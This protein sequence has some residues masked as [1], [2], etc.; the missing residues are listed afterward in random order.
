MN[1]KVYPTD[2]SDEEWAFVAPDLTLT[3]YSPLPLEP[4]EMF[5]QTNGCFL[6]ACLLS[7]EVHAERL[8]FRQRNLPL[9]S[10]MPFNAFAHAYR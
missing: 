8:F 1:R 9:G 4:T 2:G 7:C 5:Q 10:N 6:V 3:G